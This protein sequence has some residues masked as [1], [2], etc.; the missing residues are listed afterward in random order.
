MEKRAPIKTTIADA[1][2]YWSKRVDEVGLSVDWSEARSHCWRCGCEKNLERCHIIPHALD[3]KDE[4]SNIV[5][6]CKRC[7]VEGPNVSDTEVM[8]DWICA[9]SVPLYETFWSTRGMKE[10]KFIYGKSIEEDVN[11]IIRRAGIKMN[12]SELQALINRILIRVEKQCSVHFGQ[13]YLNTATIAG[14][15]RMMIKELAIKYNVNVR[16]GK[17][18]RFYFEK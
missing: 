1:V 18:G 15:Y 9:Y 7:H 14:K 11:E 4:P 2:N 6:L 16:V 12:E 13:P 8:W 3:G 5:L 17:K 10:Y